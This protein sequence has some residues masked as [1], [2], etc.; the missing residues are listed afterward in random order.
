MKESAKKSFK[1]PHLMVIVFCLIFF[2]SAMTYV[3]P[4]GQFATD[5]QTGQLIGSEFHFL[6]H[7]T[8]V[9]PWQAMLYIKDGI[10][11]SGTIIA[12]LFVAGGLTGVVLATKSID[13]LVDY[14]IYRLQDK[15]LD[16]LIPLLTLVFLLFGTFSGGDYVIAMVPIGLMI[17]RKLRVDPIVGFSVVIVA[18]VLGG[19]S[20]PTNVML[21]QM[22]M[23]VPL[24]SGFGMR[25]L[26]NIP[27]Y[28]IVIFYIWSYAKKV[29]ADP[30]RSALGFSGWQNELDSADLAGASVK[31]VDLQ[32][33]DVLVT[34]VYFLNP[35]VIVILT[36]EMGYGQEVLS[37]VMIITAFIVGLIRRFSLDEICNLFAKG[38]AGMAFV[39][40]IIGCA[41]AMSLVMG[42]GNILHTI[43]WALC[44]PLQKLGPGMAAIGIAL[45]VTLINLI[46][47]SA[48]AKVAILCPIISPM[49]DA[50]NINRQ[51]GVSAFK[52]GDSITNVISP[53]LGML[54]GGLE[55]AKIPYDK[56]VKWVMPLV[57]TLLVYSYATLYF[58]G[59]IGWTG[60]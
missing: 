18:I 56:Y 32:S 24:Y 23:E 54:L 47:P 48:S 37:A 33:R 1:M 53:V 55:I 30:S 60:L 40:F 13:N 15:G 5:P 8:P 35:I 27:V 31:K 25:L 2:M 14:S 6:G 20:S 45:V 42:N 59:V 19:T 26:L 43:V 34:I 52:Y 16:V 29:A 10:V 51:I 3:I 57:L 44:L 21:A 28:G 38:C 41:N 49:C 4:A 39:S 22:V 11:N 7:Q 36:T 12:T 17:A 46:I 50:L 9:S 58:M